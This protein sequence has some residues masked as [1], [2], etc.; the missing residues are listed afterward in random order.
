MASYMN[1]YTVIV[2]IIRQLF[3]VLNSLQLRHDQVT[4]AN[5]FM[6]YTHTCIHIYSLSGIPLM[7]H[8][9]LLKLINTRPLLSLS[10][11]EPPRHLSLPRSNVGISMN[12]PFVLMPRMTRCDFSTDLR[13]LALLHFS[14]NWF[15]FKTQISNVLMIFSTTTMSPL[16]YFSNL[17]LVKCIYFS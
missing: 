2:L 14:F 12:D 4:R 11:K 9:C 8:F 3:K 15:C 17:S 7:T 6:T 13:V 5:E 10:R 16:I 1:V